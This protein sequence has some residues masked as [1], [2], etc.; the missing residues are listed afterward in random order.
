MH[1]VDKINLSNLTRDELETWLAELG[2]PRFRAAQICEWIWKHLAT[3]I[4][5]MTNLSRKLRETLT[6]RAEVGVLTPDQTMESGDGTVKW[7]FRGNGDDIGF[8]T[9]MIPDDDRRTVCISSQIGCA[10]GCAFCRTGRMGFHRNLAAGEIAQQVAHAERY[11]AATG[12]PALTNV[13]F[14]GMGEPL[15]NFTGV[16]AAIDLL[17]DPKGLGLAAHRL[18]VSTSGITEHIP[19]LAEKRPQVHLAISLNSSND[20]MRNEMMPV[21]RRHGIDELL[22]AGDSWSAATG[23]PV[24]YEYVLVGGVTCT[25]EAAMELVALL[26]HRHCK[27]N[28]I[29]LNAADD[30][31]L[32]AP[33]EEDVVRFDDYVRSQGLVA[34]LRKSKGR[35]ILAACGQLARREN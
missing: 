32:R 26:R 11:L 1:R 35:D 19:E 3:E 4:G 2:E 6:E 8:E 10:M 17:T 13:V 34:F 9:V 31:P 15:Q 5:E 25:R 7:S 30:I 24:T 29:P 20:A 14:M 23:L 22:A 16:L 33:T 27:V 28:L 18:T 21:N 12:Q